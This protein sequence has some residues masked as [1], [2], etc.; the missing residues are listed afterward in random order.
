M[1]PFDGTINEIESLIY[2]FNLQL[3]NSEFDGTL[4]QSR[5]SK[6]WSNDPAPWSLTRRMHFLDYLELKMKVG[7][8]IAENEEEIQKE[9]TA[10]SAVLTVQK[11]LERIKTIC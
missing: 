9:D 5:Q 10:I 8:L 6:E 3:I 4:V 7:S 1:A 2:K 11:Q